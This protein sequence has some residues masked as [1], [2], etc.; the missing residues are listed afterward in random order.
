[1]DEATFQAELKSY[2]VVRRADFHK[3]Y[4]NKKYA[5][6]CFFYWAHGKLYNVEFKYIQE[7]HKHGVKA[8]AK[9]GGATAQVS[10]KPV[11]ADSSV[12]FWELLEKSLKGTM[13][14]VEINKFLACLRQVFHTHTRSMTSIFPI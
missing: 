11:S 9:K 10:P 1:M 13:T 5:V 6:G 12:G 7:Q 8:H 14:P 4:Y 3:V 2:K